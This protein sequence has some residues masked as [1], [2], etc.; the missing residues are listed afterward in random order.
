MSTPPIRVVV[1]DDTEP[2]R[3]AKSRIL[4]KAGFEVLEAATGAEAFALVDS[5]APDVVVLD[6]QLPDTNGWEVCKQLK[7]RGLEAP[8]V[9]QVSA[10]YVEDGDTV[11]ALE[12]GADACLT[13][14]IDPAVLVATVRALLR[15]RRAEQAL[16]EALT[17]EQALRQAAEGANRAKD[18]F[19]ATLSHE[20][21][22]PLGT[23]LTW[24]TLLKEGRLDAA[25]SRQGLDAIERS[26]QLQVK[27]I[28]DLLDVSSILSGKTRLD[29]GSVDLV[30]VVH[31]A[32]ESIA[33]SAA[34]KRLTVSSH[35]D[36]EVPRI[37]GDAMRLLQVVQN[38]CSNA[39][40]FTPAGGR[41]A[42]AVRLVNDVVEIEVSDTGK[43]IARE[44]LPHI[45]ERFRQA[46]ASTTRFEGGL[47]L[48]LA[49]VLH[50]VQ[51]HHGSVEARSE[52]TGRGTTF[53]VRL[54][55]AAITTGTPA[56]DVSQA[57]SGSADPNALAGLRILLV[58]DEDDAREAV[59]TA[60]DQR[61]ARVVTA[62]SVEAALRAI[63]EHA[64]DVMIGDIAMPGEDGYS[65]IRRLRERAAEA[66]GGTPAVAL[67]AYGRLID[68]TRILAAGY[69][70]CL[71]KPV[72]I[73]ELAAALRRVARR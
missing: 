9:L 36:A 59:A 38:L 26:T 5:H 45:F 43:G 1:V 42:V 41:I 54:P 68:R 34:A 13:E 8:L 58:D 23:I 48:G 44:F 29:I 16:R 22:S 14:P 40:K 66:G 69:D 73:D 7:Q 17:R 37:A 15:M 39:V 12:G 3:Y 21:R 51:M 47:G 53:I 33:A 67:T 52:G 46:D 56:V 31:A 18:E 62:A 28:G 55:G 57:R 4:R 72:P 19:L 6:T 49:I 2:N 32:V 25:R 24:V 11:K 10:T 30:A 20:L 70:E 60:L 61:G 50:L 35:I 63:G 65:L 71:A 64:P 27:L